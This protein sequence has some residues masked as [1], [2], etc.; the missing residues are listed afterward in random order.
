MFKII[1]SHTA[2]DG[3]KNLPKRLKERIIELLDVLETEPVPIE[4]Y[5]VKRMKGL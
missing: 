3:A 1:I 2:R 4:K 5:D